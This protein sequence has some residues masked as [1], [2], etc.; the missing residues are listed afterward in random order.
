MVFWGTLLAASSLLLS[1]TSSVSAAKS[2]PNL[3]FG[4]V[5]AVPKVA[6]P[7]D[8]PLKDGVALPPYN[9]W[10]YFDQLI[11]H[12]N[13]SLGTFKQRYYFTY[14]YYKPGG[15]IVMVC[16]VTETWCRFLFLT[17]C[18]DD[19][20]RRQRRRISRLS[21]QPYRQRPDHERKPRR[22]S[23]HRASLLRSLQPLPR[24]LRRILPRTH[25]RPGYR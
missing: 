19:T 23:R 12:Q 6:A 22:S 3:N 18:A 4:P 25:R 17:V 14:E 11:D 7:D 5:P 2:R 9:T 15:P 20:R 1:F 10:Y 13:P 24:P 8:A 16:L 21:H